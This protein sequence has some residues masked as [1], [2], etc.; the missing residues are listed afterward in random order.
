MA[1][2]KKPRSTCR[3]WVLLIF[4][5]AVSAWTAAGT[6]GWAGLL[7]PVFE[8]LGPFAFPCLLIPLTTWPGHEVILILSGVGAGANRL[9]ALSVSSA[10][11][12]FLWSIFLWIPVL[13]LYWRK[14]PMWLG[15]VGQ[16]F[17]LLV[18]CMLFWR[19]GSG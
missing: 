18:V 17:V 7:K 8:R 2:N 6:V 9:S 19:F 16:L 10:M 11:V 13:T 14:V 5:G 3:K 4:V 15:L 12:F 1:E